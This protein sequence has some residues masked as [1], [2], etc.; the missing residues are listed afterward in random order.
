MCVI[1]R[2]VWNI[3]YYIFIFTFFNFLKQNKRWRRKKI[4][5]K[6]FLLCNCLVIFGKR[7]H[8]KCH[9][10]VTCRY[11]KNKIK[12]NKCN[13]THIQ[14]ENKTRMSIYHSARSPLLRNTGNFTNPF[15]IYLPFIYPLS[16]VSIVCM[17]W[18]SFGFHFDE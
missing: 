14:V 16:I 10:K 5:W 7:K 17:A 4:T 3:D 11:E 1:V 9:D 18:M 8:I 6:N 12:L 15:I 13:D 2:N